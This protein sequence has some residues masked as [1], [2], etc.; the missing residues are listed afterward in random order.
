M[1]QSY[2]GTWDDTGIR[3]L[4]R[5]EGAA[6]GVPR[7]SGG[8]P[9]WAVLDSDHVLGIHAALIRGQRGTALQLLLQQAREFG[10]LLR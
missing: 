1:W 10:R 5:E 9:F 3:S 7:E 6:T 2:I 4:R 8:V